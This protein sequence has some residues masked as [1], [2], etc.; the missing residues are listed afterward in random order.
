[1][2][3]T[4]TRW[5]DPAA[6][7]T[8]RLCARK[9]DLL[10]RRSR[11]VTIAGPPPFRQRVRRCG[12]WLP[13]VCRPLLTGLI[14]DARRCRR[15]P[16]P[17]RVRDRGDQQRCCCSR[18]HGIGRHRDWRCAGRDKVVIST[19][20]HHLLSA[21][22]ATAARPGTRALAPPQSRSEL[23]PS[24]WRRPRRVRRS[25]GWTSTSCAPSQVRHLGLRGS[26]AAPRRAP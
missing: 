14:V 23:P 15:P 18:H 4:V 16:V 13:F 19:P 22:S 6:A 8:A 25:T 7:C 21:L 5:C 17:G 12:R 26:S 24:C 9:A 1:M 11:A 10:Q 20:A 2:S 3:L